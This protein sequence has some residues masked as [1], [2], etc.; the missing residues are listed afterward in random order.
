M[1]IESLGSLNKSYNSFYTYFSTGPCLQLGRK[2]CGVF[3]FRTQ[4][5][6]FRQFWIVSNT[7]LHALLLSLQIPALNRVIYFSLS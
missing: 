3:S 6:L 5:T 2:F 7:P 4:L 1:V